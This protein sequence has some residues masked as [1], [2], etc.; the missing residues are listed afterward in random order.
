MIADIETSLKQCEESCSAHP[1]PE[2]I[3]RLENLKA[4]YNHIFEDISKG[5]IIRSRATWYEKGEKSN[6]FFVNLKNHRKSKSTV[7]WP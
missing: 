2:N 6:N 5:A 1:S 4:E 7:V 3:E